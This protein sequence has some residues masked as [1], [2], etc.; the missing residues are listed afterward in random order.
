LKI[1]HFCDDIAQ[2]DWQY[3]TDLWNNAAH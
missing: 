1:T 2:N 3:R